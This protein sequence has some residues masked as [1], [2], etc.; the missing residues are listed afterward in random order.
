MIA[1]NRIVKYSMTQPTKLLWSPSSCFVLS[2]SHVSPK[3][4]YPRL[5]PPLQGT[6]AVWDTERTLDVLEVSGTN[7]VMYS[8]CVCVC[9]CVRLKL[10]GT[11][12]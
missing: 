7:F 2:Q 4:W 11:L 5:I 8:M 3:N 10:H 12:W 6:M 1:L 9:V